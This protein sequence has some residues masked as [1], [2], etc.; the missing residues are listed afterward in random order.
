MGL[1]QT[2]V[3]A[4]YAASATSQFSLKD[5]QNQG[6]GQA[7]ATGVYLSEAGNAGT[8]QQIDLAV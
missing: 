4:I 2:G 3:G 6:L 7:L 5:A 8:I 1:G